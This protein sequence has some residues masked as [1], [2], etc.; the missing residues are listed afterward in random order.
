MHQADMIRAALE[1]H[2]AGRL[3]E[4]EAT[5]RA[6]LQQPLEAR[7]GA[8]CYQ[9][10][11]FVLEDCGR[12]A[13]AAEAYRAAARLNPAD[14][15]IHSN[16][17]SA[18]IRSGALQEA[19][20]VARN[21][22]TLF[23]QSAELQ[24]QLGIAL[25]AQDNPAGALAHFDRALALRH[26]EADFH[27]N[28]AVALIDLLRF[29][30][31]IA[32]LEVAIALRH[33]CAEAHARLGM[34][35]LTTGDFRRGWREYE[36]RQRWTRAT[37]LPIT[38]DGS[39]PQGKTIVLDA[40]QGLGDA[41]Q[42][43]RY[44]QLVAQ[45]GAEVVI[46]APPPLH[47]LLSGAAGVTKVIG[48]GDSVGGA[49]RFPLMA[50]PKLFDTTI[51]TIPAANPYIVCDPKLVARWGDR[52]GRGGRRKIGIVWSG[53]PAH[54]DDQ[55]RSCRLSD[56]AP[57][58]GVANV[59]LLSLQIG[60]SARQIRDCGFA[61]EDLSLHLTDLA[62]TAAAMMH[63]D[64]IITV[65]TA[66]A[67]L[68]GAIGRPVWV[69]LASQPEWRWMLDRQDSPWYPTMRLFRQRERGQWDDPVARAAAE[70]ER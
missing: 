13:E 64:L 46:A 54:R 44:A 32:A 6:V 42:F 29:D 58:A 70:L 69:L 37:A 67:H 3:R 11:A 27:Y 31:A 35:L 1:H 19:D 7:V 23:P 33:D 12:H 18:L 10:L 66:V 55:Q 47:R 45:R 61:I 60:E 8:D 4:A 5:F 24:N 25:T 65:D 63:L 56:F 2:Q 57:L 51:E 53:N 34:A 36:W 17:A 43:V 49:E 41:I 14:A 50:L 39:D 22:A 15:I 26:D 59:D 52:I 62:E 21:A 38:W 68:A 30:E 9:H 20:R 40:E 28:R 48:I 16:L